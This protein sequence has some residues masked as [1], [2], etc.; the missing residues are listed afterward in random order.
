MCSWK[1]SLH[2]GLLIFPKFLPKVAFHSNN[3]RNREALVLFSPYLR[4]SF[5]VSQFFF[6]II[7]KLLPLPFFLS[8]FFFKWKIAKSHTF[9]DDKITSC[10][11][12]SSGWKEIWLSWSYENLL[13]NPTLFMNPPWSKNYVTHYQWNKRSHTETFTVDPRPVKLYVLYCFLGA[14]RV[15]FKTSGISQRGEKKTL[16][17]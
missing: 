13:L 8:F 6:S 14:K 16:V 9:S 1:H 2:I 7:L 17:V 11:S 15:A 12:S 10:I 3:I 5:K 4:Q